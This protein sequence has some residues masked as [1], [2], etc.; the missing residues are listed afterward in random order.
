LRGILITPEGEKVILPV[1]QTAPGNY[2]FEISSPGEGTTLITLV[3][4]D[5]RIAP[6]T[7]GISIPYGDEYRPQKVNQLLLNRIAGMSGGGLFPLTDEGIEHYIASST[8]SVKIPEEIWPALV[9]ALIV[10]FILDIA[11]RQ[12]PKGF[13]RIRKKQKEIKRRHTREG[14]CPTGLDGRYSTI[15]EGST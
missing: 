6:S 14:T 4:Q 13:F 5:G 10:L 1:D 2:T 8:G 3:E 9:L 7:F 12:L 15:K 11:L